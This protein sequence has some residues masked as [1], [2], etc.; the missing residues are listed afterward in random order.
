MQR[1]FTLI[2]MMLVVLIFILLFA[3]LL[4]VFINSDHI[5]RTSQ[6]EITEQQ[7]ARKAMDGIV[8]LLRQSK[9]EWVRIS[10]DQAGSTKI[11]FYKPVFIQPIETGAYVIFKL[12]PLNGRELVKKESDIDANFVGLAQDI[13]WINFGGGCA[14][15]L[16]FNCSPVDDSCPIVRI[17][18][19]TWREE[20]SYHLRSFVNLRNFNIVAGGAPVPPPEGEF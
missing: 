14:G 20:A 12:N 8:R 10:A 19:V 5:W 18:I 1:A 16:A 2:E 15:C 17:D 7:Q 6:N 11:L 4:T 9:P 13:E 3:A